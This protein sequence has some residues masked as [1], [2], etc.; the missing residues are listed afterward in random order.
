MKLKKFSTDKKYQTFLIGLILLI[1]ILLIA[2]VFIKTFAIFESHQ[3]YDVIKGIVP[4]YNQK[5]V[6]LAVVV[7]HQ[8]S[9][10]IP[11]K[12]SSF[13][14]EK[15]ECDKNISPLWNNQTWQLE[16]KEITEKTKCT[17]FF[18]T[19]KEKGKLLKDAII[20]QEGTREQ[21][22]L[23]G[24]PDFSLSA[25]TDEGLLE[26]TDDYGKTYYYRG[27]VSDNYVY[28]ANFYWRI[29]RVN[30]DNSIRLIYQGPKIDSTKTESQ[31]TYA[32]WQSNDYD[33]AY[34]GYMFGTVGGTDYSSTHENIFQS[35][36]KLVI[37][38]WYE[39]NLKSYDSYLSDNL[40]CNDRS[41]NQNPISQPPYNDTGLGY[42]KNI[43]I[44][45]PYYRIAINH[46]PTF[47]CPQKNDRFT[48][49]DT[50]LGNGKLTY[51]IGLIT[52]DEA[53][54]AGAI[55]EQSDINQNNYLKTGEWFFTMSP[56]AFWGKGVL[57]MM[58]VRGYGDI[59]VYDMKSGI[60]IRPVINL[61]ESSTIE[62]GNGSKENPFII[63]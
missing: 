60:G 5:D 28:F 44:Y 4:N 49:S 12:N 9:K 61:K 14:Y 15:V 26:G 47:M 7:D 6:S 27:N 35:S 63:S 25:N 53:N 38:Q 46:Q 23:K 36:I 20:E 2:I 57:D 21:I 39:S 34:A 51:P 31:I 8:Y 1:L 11:E 3:E 13:V 40:F 59:Y 56:G 32:P 17:I 37:D 54:F 24:V 22:S 55:S 33:N 48:V 45:M 30:G 18:Q 43:T 62:K 10:T 41:V 29:I 50:L 52:A 42:G 19:S 16:L 58:D